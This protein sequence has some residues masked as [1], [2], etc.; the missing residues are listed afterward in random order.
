MYT[1][2]DRRDRLTH[3]PLICV[4][5]DQENPITVDTSDLVMVRNTI[6]E[7]IRLFMQR[8]GTVRPGGSHILILSHCEP[9]KEG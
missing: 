9:H 8:I 2:K 1:V 6:N 4:E 7:A 5:A 3:M